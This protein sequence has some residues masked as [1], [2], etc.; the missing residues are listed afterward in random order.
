MTLRVKADRLQSLVETLG[1]E[2]RQLVMLTQ[3]VPYSAE[4]SGKVGAD[5]K[6][7]GSRNIILK[8]D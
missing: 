2:G 5:T 6:V 7:L 4:V 8:N 3:G 1:R